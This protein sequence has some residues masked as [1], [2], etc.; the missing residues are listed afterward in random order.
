MTDPTES[1]IAATRLPAHVTEPARVTTV[2]P[3]GQTVRPPA[4]NLRDVA[5]RAGHC[6]VAGIN[7][8]VAEGETIA[9][10]GPVGSGKTTLLR[11]IAGVFPPTSGIVEADDQPLAS[12]APENRQIAWVPQAAGLFP[13]LT[14]A[15]QIEFACAATGT[16]TR[17]V[18]EHANKWGIESLLD[19]RPETLSGGEKQLVALA[20]ATI[21]RPRG[22]LLDEPFSALSAEQRAAADAMLA[23]WRA[24]GPP[25]WVIHAGHRPEEVA[26]ATQ[27]WIL[28][29]GSLQTA[30]IGR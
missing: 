11:V 12:V 4:L 1:R 3:V 19:R 9:L 10:G 23:A 18:L 14:V 13:R 22:L 20:R 6:A 5:Y 8:T 16:P 2:D 29:D 24:A 26:G 30:Q 27:Q 15:Q 17:S 25:V 28:S 21:H 7:A